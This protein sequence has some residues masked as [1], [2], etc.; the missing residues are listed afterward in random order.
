M[1]VSDPIEPAALQAVADCLLTH[2]WID[3][4]DLAGEG[5]VTLAVAPEAMAVRRR[6]GTAASLGGLVAEHLDQWAEVYDSAYAAGPPADPEL[7]I[8]GWRASDT[9]QPLPR[10]WM[11]EW[12]DRS[13]ELVLRTGARRVL[14]V[15]CGTG[16]LLRRLHGRISGYV[17]LDVAEGVVR[18]IDSLGLPGVRVLQAAAHELGG[19]QVAEALSSLG[20]APDCIV[21]NSVTQCFPSVGY[22]SAVLH[23]AVGL[24][25][26]GG[27]VV[28][29]DVRHAGLLQAFALWATGAGAIGSPAGVDLVAERV[30]AETEL[31]FDPATLAIIAACAP[32]PVA[33]TA[34]A[35]TLTADSE[36]SRY[37]FDAVLQVDPEDAPGAEVVTWA[38][39]AGTTDHGGGD[40]NGVAL[41][42]RAFLDGCFSPLRVRGVPNR[43]LADTPG[44]STGAALQEA[45]FGLDAAVL[46]DTDDPTCLAVACPALAGRCGVEDFLE[47]ANAHEPLASFARSRVV[48]AAR[49]VVRASRLTVPV[50]LSANVPSAIGDGR[51]RVTSQ[52]AAADAVGRDRLAVDGATIRAGQLGRVPLAAQQL[53]EIALQAL[54]AHL[55]ETGALGADVARGAEEVAAILGTAER[56]VW[57]VRRWLRVLAAEGRATVDD[58]D[59]YRLLPAGRR[60]DLDPAAA[61]LDRACRRLGYPPEMAAFFRTAFAHMADLLADRVMAQSLLFPEG[62]LLVALSKDQ[63]NLSNRYLHAAAGAVVA[64]AAATRRAPLRIV[65]VDAGG[66]GGTAAVVSALGDAPF[67]YLFSDVS[68]F[69]TAAATERFSGVAGVRYELLDINRDLVDQGAPASGADVVLA[70]NVL[71]CATGMGA[72][73]RHLRRLLA[74]GG[75]LVVVE[76]VREHY[77]VL[78][79]MQFLLSPRGGGSPPGVGDRRAGSDCVFLSGTELR[80]E[81]AG[82][83]LRPLYELPTADSPLAAPAQ[84]LV[85]ACR[86]ADPHA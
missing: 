81:L 35:K 45:L 84:R 56:H 17:G 40:P 28:V 66:G 54:A 75:V 49:R 19:Q 26:P 46:V 37:R 65:E 83:G 21:L 2:D 73:L 31:L 34:L 12:A 61:L 3:R 24:V 33:V 77:I 29:G 25:S 50:A 11:A 5:G 27:T 43:L 74:P 32:R 9:G 58:A 44:G 76:A 62:D 20:A 82:A 59:R 69:F 30:A 18:R 70:G 39:V 42:V 63:N 55:A 53:D 22:L 67:D 71:H 86:L 48:E 79:T 80:A 51:L 4:V 68:A 41:S 57:I 72:S 16:I 6:L 14:E 85:V 78:A 60:A 1:N 10:E 64:Q 23:D 38:E 36:L 15:G 47:P 13:A 7:D 8:A 52:A